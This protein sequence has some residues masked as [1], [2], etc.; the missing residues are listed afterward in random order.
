M[1]Q[2]DA[3]APSGGDG[4]QSSGGDG[5]DDVPDGGAADGGTDSPHVAAAPDC[6]LNG[7]WIGR[8]ITDNVADAFPVSQYANNWYYLE[9]QQDSEDV[10]VSKHFDCGI[11]VLGSA[12]RV[13][14]TPATTTALSQHN[15][16][17]GRKGTFKKQ[18]NGTC[19]FEMERFW[20]VRGL[21]E[22]TYVPTPR[23]STKSIAE[24]SETIPLPTKNQ[25]DLS[26]DWDGDGQPGT[27]WHVSGLTNGTR[28]SAQRDWT[29]WFSTSSYAIASSTT[30]P[31]PLLV[32]AEFDS[33]E[34]V[35]EPKSGSITSGSKPNGRV[36]HTLTLKFLGRSPSDAAVKQIVTKDVFETCRNIQAALPAIQGLK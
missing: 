28:H 34:V 36:E 19:A 35:F 22:S 3:S 27:A 7:V 14:L 30:W 5:D 11:L 23:N 9:F 31:N 6:D 29:R 13:E 18:S 1:V 20:S 16:Q 24:V 4:D 8:Q 10:V 2:F 21:D 12:A 15:L 17:R 25:P 33:Q 32:R 26:Q